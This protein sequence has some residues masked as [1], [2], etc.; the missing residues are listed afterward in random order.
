VITELVTA[1]ISV[2][3]DCTSPISIPV[4]PEPLPTKEPD[5][6]PPI[7]SN[8]PVISAAPV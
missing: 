6:V 3:I 2:L 1:V 7:T 4:S 8:E 5:I